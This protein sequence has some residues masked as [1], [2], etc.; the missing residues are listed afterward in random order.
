VNLEAL[1]D[2]ALEY[3]DQIE[4]VSPASAREALREHLDAMKASI[5]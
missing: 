2:W 5:A 1:I 4:I 3:G